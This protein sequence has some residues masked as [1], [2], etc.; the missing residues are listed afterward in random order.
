MTNGA[1]WNDALRRAETHAPFLARAM[2]RLPDLAQLLA[3]GAGETALDWARAQGPASAAQVPG[4]VGRAL[5]RE[6][7]AFALA[8]AVGDLAGAFPLARV[9]AELSAL[10]DRALDAAITDAIRRRTPDAAV[11]VRNSGFIALALGKHGAQELNYSS[12]IDP[13]LLY[14]PQRLPRRQRD[15]PGEAAEAMARHVV[16]TLSHV[17]ADGYVFRVDLRLRPASEISP[18]AIPVDAALSHYESSALAWERAAF[19]RARA[20]AGDIAAGGAFLSAIRPFVWRKSLDFGAIAEIGR[21][22]RRIRAAHGQI[23]RP[24]PG[25]DLKRGRG[26]IREIEFF[27]QTHQLIHGGR[28]PALRLRGTRA[29]LDALAAGGFIAIEDA[30]LLGQSYDRLRSVEHR[31]QMVEDRQTHTLPRD[32]ALLDGV[33]RLDGLSDSVALVAELVQITGAVGD[34]YDMLIAEQTNRPVRREA[35]PAVHGGALADELARLGFAEPAVLAA[36]ID[37]WRGGAVRA[38]RS[39]AAIAAL[40]RVQAPLLAA[41][42]KAAEP[43]RALTRWE[44]MIAGLPSAVNLFRLLEARPAL[45]E[46]LVRIL[47]LAP[48]LADALARRSDLLDALI[49]ASAFDLPGAIQALAV[50]L[51]RGESDDDYQR[52]LDRV[53]RR[54]TEKRFALGVQLIEAA[55]DPLA[56]SAGLSRVAEAAIEVLG[57]GAV[58]EFERAHG[59]VP[60]SEMVML[61][62]GRLGGG[63]LTPASDLDIIYLFTGDHGGESDGARPLGATQYFNRLAQR[64]TAA[65]SVATAEGVLYEVD[66]RL[67]PQGAQGLLAVNYASFVAYQR[68]QAWTWEHMAL[69]RARPVFGS[70][71]ARDG[72]EALIADV[73]DTPREPEKLHREV[74]EMRARMAVH[75]HPK[76]PLDVKLRRGGLVDLEFVTHYLQLRQRIALTP[77]LRAAITQLVDGGWLAPVMI[78]AHDFLTRLLFAARLLAPDAAEPPLPARAALAKACGCGDWAGVLTTLAAMRQTVIA[79]WTSVFGETVEMD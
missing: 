77:N 66:T 17:D 39:D 6:R 75:K 3:A 1:D 26:G 2:A 46:L 23:E 24:G 52:L 50:E 13:I 62:L 51:A 71:A 78:D 18:L 34:R 58:A 53:R 79:A 21:L 31:L 7:L 9:M 15:D 49:D 70:A 19:I 55:H 59:R 64:I 68:A 48:P 5:R 43:T 69:I 33:A 72:I 36:R 47:S 63:A 25:F 10:A 4:E 42:A 14:D 37:G 67:R 56:I 22:A 45:L 41:L 74:L 65:L 29:S 16:Q 30:R 57:A 38:L 27:A 44:Q 32:P 73:L 60:G 61:G 54:V 28:H 76:G 8:L 35:D 11:D 20:A 12:D 40:D